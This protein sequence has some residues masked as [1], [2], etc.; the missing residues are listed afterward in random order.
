MPISDAKDNNVSD[1]Q[2]VTATET[3]GHAHAHAHETKVLRSA[4][5][6]APASHPQMIPNDRVSS[7]LL[8]L[9]MAMALPLFRC[10]YVWSQFE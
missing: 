10:I 5:I 4:T 7:L 2:M 1:N 8:I 6:C 9:A 3:L